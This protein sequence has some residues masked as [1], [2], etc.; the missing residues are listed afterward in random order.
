[1]PVLK[2]PRHER[3]AQELAKGK[4]QTEAYVIAGYKESLPHASRL[5]TKGNVL[6][7][8]KELKTRV[9][10]AVVQS[11]ILTESEVLGQ[12][13]RILFADARKLFA[14]DGTLKPIHTIDDDTA[15]AI[16]GI[17]IVE[18][19]QSI[20]MVKDPDEGE[21]QLTKTLE[22]TKKIK[23][24]DKLKAVDL[25]MQHLG[26]LRT[27]VTHTHEHKV[28][29]ELMNAVVGMDRSQLASMIAEML[30]ALP[31]RQALTI[32]HGVAATG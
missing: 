21:D 4:T 6:Q 16:A 14:A 28:P 7:R 22:Q 32:E 13:R 23:L 30:S 1:M 12:L 17:D 5:A 24:L 10:E 9:A 3:F 8:V 2:N 18:S 26:L 19:T 25:A 31:R 27:R 11:Q 15:A 20:K 29:P